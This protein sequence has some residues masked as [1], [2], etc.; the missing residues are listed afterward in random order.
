[1][2]RLAVFNT[3]FLREASNV[4]TPLNI[5]KIQGSGRDGLR[6]VFPSLLFQAP[7][8][9][10]I[11]VVLPCLEKLTGFA[12]PTISLVQ[13]GCKSYARSQFGDSLTCSAETPWMATGWLNAKIQASEPSI[14]FHDRLAPLA[15]MSI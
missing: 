14:D 2:F 10:Y 12:C 3:A 1:M 11:D 7:K 9:P 6:Q 13:A 8:A 15:V 5:G 4:G